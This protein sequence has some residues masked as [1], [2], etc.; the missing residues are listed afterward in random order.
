[1]RNQVLTRQAVLPGVIVGKM[2]SGSCQY[3]FILWGLA[4]SS[5]PERCAPLSLR[6]SVIASCMSNRNPVPRACIEAYY[7]DSLSANHELA[8]VVKGV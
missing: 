4:V 2:L 8:L 7:D 5:E 6:G 1:M 3:I